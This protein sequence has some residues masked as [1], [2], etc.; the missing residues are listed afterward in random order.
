MLPSIFIQRIRSNSIRI[1]DQPLLP[2]LPINLIRIIERE[3]SEHAGGVHSLEF[4]G[5]VGASLRGEVGIED[6]GGG[7]GFLFDDCADEGEGVGEG[8]VEAV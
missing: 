2:I 5:D 8:G 3:R 7:D 4:G 1:T 6:G